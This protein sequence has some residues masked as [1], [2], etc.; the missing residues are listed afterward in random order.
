[1]AKWSL[2]HPP[3]LVPKLQKQVMLQMANLRHCRNTSPM[4]MAHHFRFVVV[5]K[6]HLQIK[7]NIN[8]EGIMVIFL[9]IFLLI[10]INIIRHYR[11][12]GIIIHVLIV[13]HPS[14]VLPSVVRDQIC[15]RSLCRPRRKH[16]INIQLH[17]GRKRRLNMSG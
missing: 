8:M 1:M 15:T 10:I 5:N 16:Y 17:N 12:C 9:P 7:V 2:D 11:T 3:I 6:I 14:I 13:I 4:V